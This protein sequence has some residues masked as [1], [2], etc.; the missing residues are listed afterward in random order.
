MPD[1]VAALIDTPDEELL[2]LIDSLLDDLAPLFIRDPGD[3][4]AGR[5]RALLAML[6]YHP[7][8]AADYL[9]A[10]QI[11]GHTRLGITLMREAADPATPQAMRLQM[12]SRIQSLSRTA[13]Q[14]E[15]MMVRRHK[16]ELAEAEAATV[17][18]PG[19]PADAALP[20]SD[21]DFEAML[22][23]TNAMVARASLS[24]APDQPAQQLDH[25][26]A[27]LLPTA[28]ERAW[29]D[30]ETSETPW[31]NSSAM[32]LPGLIPAETRPPLPG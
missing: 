7:R 16:R 27:P 25:M 1:T 18:P 22:R 15:T 20:Q 24:A 9:S 4:P 11:V 3:L 21:P 19:P 26:T 5:R 12:T 8:S 32:P 6:A 31:Q 29:A 13:A 30:A 14:V 23:A 10:A 2:D 17:A 28:S